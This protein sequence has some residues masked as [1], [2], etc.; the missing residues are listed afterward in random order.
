MGLHEKRADWIRLKKCAAGL[1]GGWSFSGQT[2]APL[3]LDVTGILAAVKR[4]APKDTAKEAYGILKQVYVYFEGLKPNGDQKE[5]VRNFENAKAAVLAYYTLN[6]VLFGKI[7]GD[8]DNDRENA[9]FES[10]L[11]Q[12]ADDSN[13]KV[14]AGELKVTVDRLG[15][16]ADGELAVGQARGLLRDQLKNF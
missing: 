1:G 12:L 10:A 9:A 13:V 7:V 2:L 14:D 16:S 15:L 4:Q 3:S 5:N 11:M 8:A 6:D